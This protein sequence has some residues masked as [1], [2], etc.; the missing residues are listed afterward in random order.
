MNAADLLRKCAAEMQEHN[1]SAGHRTPKAMILACEEAARAL[2][3]DE[4]SEAEE[5]RL[6][7]LHEA[8]AACWVVV[9]R[10]RNCPG[11]EKAAGECFSAVRRLMEPE[12]IRASQPIP[13][14]HPGCTATATRRYQLCDHCWLDRC[15]HKEP[16]RG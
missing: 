14:I 1:D 8:V 11:E 10:W 9:E 12:E 7:A 6:Q 16:R 4:L 5:A 2:A 15:D 3:G 13:C